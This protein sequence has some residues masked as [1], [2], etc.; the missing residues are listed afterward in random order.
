MTARPDALDV[1]S[2]SQD[3]R[4]G[5]HSPRGLPSPR[6]AHADGDIPPTLSPLDAFAAQGRLLAKQLDD[7][8]RDGKRVSRLP[9]LTI[10]NSLA[11]PRPGYSRSAS[12]DDGP[13]SNGP[14]AHTRPDGGL[15]LGVRSAVETPD[16]RPRSVHPR[17]SGMPP[18]D[19][20][21][22]AQ[23]DMLTNLGRERGRQAPGLQP[24]GWSGLGPRTEQSP[25]R[26]T[27]A[28]RELSAM[29]HGVS[30][31]RPQRSFDSG[32]GPG[33][34]A[35]AMASEGGSSHVHNPRALAPPRFGHRRNPS[36]IRSVPA[37]DT[38][39][40]DR[41]SNG[42]RKMSSSS[43]ISASTPPRSPLHPLPMRRSPSISSEYSIGGTRHPR[44]ALNFSRPLSRASGPSLDLPSRQTSTDSQQP[45][46]FNDDA[47]HT[48]V[49]I[50]SEENG[51]GSDPF[52]Q[53][54][55]SYIYSSFVLPRGRVLQREQDSFP[56]HVS[57]EPPR[58]QWE[59]PSIPANSARST[60]P[61]T[62]EQPLSPREVPPEPAPAPTPAPAPASGT[63]NSPDRNA[64]QHMSPLRT[65]VSAGPGAAS[66]LNEVLS[67]PK[68]SGDHSRPSTS[69]M[70]STVTV[71]AATSRQTATSAEISAEEHLAR[72][73]EC[74]ERGSVNESTY[75]LRIAAKANHPT[76]MLLY[77]LACRHGWGMRPNP[78]EG[79]QWL[80]KAA[81]SAGLE[82]ADDENAPREEKAGDAAERRTRQAQF[83][84]SIYELGVSHMNG[85]GIEQDKGLALRCFEIA[86][87]WGD[88][89]ALAEAGFC[90]AQGV[91][92][93]KDLKKAAKFYRLAEGK[94]MSMVGN[95]WIYKAKYMDEDERKGR[96]QKVAEGGEKK[97]RDKSRTRTIF[98]R[99]KS[100]AAS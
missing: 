49:S 73:I 69:S 59:D 70:A 72:G 24:N 44:G 13:S 78:K 43:G 45:Y 95:S 96:G 90:Y 64:P 48:P 8:N 2:R 10:A 46:V 20:N 17:L 100:F 83:A 62:D 1:R 98:A 51:D 31:M 6:T 4:S 25:Q 88:G 38:D 26:L 55:P 67:R 32:N 66:P 5:P 27:D 50:N 33:L 53:P 37:E 21:D 65:Q 74:H 60:S 41:A 97:P 19:F 23:L 56:G 91:G 52:H 58:V 29:T 82:V 92:C 57:H 11:R 28:T 7:K 12:A 84:L 36:S 22:K 30:L 99:K 16:M 68:T 87:M 14:L 86:G 63:R 40:E 61:L 9:P 3:S 34:A 76:A 81:D 35:S 93:K 77:A 89:D 18:P 42:H 15:G 79:V 80:R 94:G 71:K 54:V 47:V 75:H 39:D 85:W